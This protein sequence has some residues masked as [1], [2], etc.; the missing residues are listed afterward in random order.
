MPV[1]DVCVIAAINWPRRQ[2]P[3]DK[4]PVRLRLRMF[5]ALHSKTGATGSYMVGFGT[6]MASKEIYVFEHELY[7]APDFTES[8]NAEVEAMAA[9]VRAVGKEEIDRCLA[10]IKDEETWQ[11]MKL[12]Y[13]EMSASKKENKS[14]NRSRINE[15]YQQELANTCG[16]WN[17]SIWLIGSWPRCPSPS[18]PSW[19]R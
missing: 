15:A 2:R 3:I 1:L 17:R 4:P 18:R 10:A 16:T 9:E 11:Y 14:A 13:E 19:S 8:I 5:T 7:C 12:S 6:W